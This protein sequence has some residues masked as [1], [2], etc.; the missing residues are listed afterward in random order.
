M[1]PKCGISNNNTASSCALG[2]E[3]N[4]APNH[5]SQILGAPS[6]TEL[7]NMTLTGTAHIL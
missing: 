3:E 6:L 2:M 7:Q 1:S 4:T 5:V